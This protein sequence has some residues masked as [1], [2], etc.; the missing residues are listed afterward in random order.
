MGALLVQDG[1]VVS[2]FSRKFNDAQLKNTVKG[3]ELLAASEACKHFGQIIC[4]CEIRVH[5]DHQNLTHNDTVHVN[6]RE[7]RTR[8]LICPHLR[9]HRGH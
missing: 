9:P 2:T 3:Q 1:N 7:Q 5:T 8:I 6:L 4:G